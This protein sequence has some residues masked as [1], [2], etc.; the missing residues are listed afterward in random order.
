MILGD[1]T[2][3]ARHLPSASA[4]LV[5][6]DPPYNLDRQ[7]NARRFARRGHAAYRDYLEGFFPDIIRLLKPS[8]SLY[9][10]ADWRSAAVIQPL[11]EEHLILRSRI[12]WE[13]EKG[14]GARDNWKNA[15]EDIFYAT[16]SESFT[17]NLDAVKLRRRV[18]APYRDDRDQ[19]K[20]WQEEGEERFRLTHPSNIWTDLT[21]PF[22][23]MPENTD[24]PTQKPEKLLARIIL[25][26]THPGDLVLDPFA[27][28]GTSAVV[29]QKLGRR[30]ASVEIDEEYALLG[31][32]RLELAADDTA[33]QGYEDGVFYERNTRPPAR[34]GGKGFTVP[35]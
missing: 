7:F 21:V 3:V 4:D 2:R 19:P 13:R 10:C 23:S 18:I 11:I 26:S 17:F 24:H 1:F 31:L 30:W 22:W 12:T 34:R 32:R 15:A 28:S 33:I 35:R 20:D 5:F 14:R 6:L 9:F 25:A 27:G 8:G 16:V 29:A